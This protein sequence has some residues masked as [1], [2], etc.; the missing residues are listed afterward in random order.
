MMAMEMFEDFHINIFVQYKYS[1]NETYKYPVLR[2]DQ[3]DIE[4]H[5]EIIDV[6]N[7]TLVLID[8]IIMVR[9]IY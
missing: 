9:F 3:Y 5:F 7:C 6:L 4:C 8:V 1:T 2:Y